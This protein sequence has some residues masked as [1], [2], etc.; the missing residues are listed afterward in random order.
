LSISITPSNGFTSRFWHAIN[1]SPS[2]IKRSH[3][4]RSY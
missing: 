3:F 2:S 1:I 4:G